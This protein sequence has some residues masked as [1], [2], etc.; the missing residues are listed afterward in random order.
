[1]IELDNFFQ[2]TIPVTKSFIEYIKHHPMVFEVFGHYQVQALHKVSMPEAA[3]GAQVG[4]G[5][6][7]SISCPKG[8]EM[9]G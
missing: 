4:S 2:I 8:G 1:M 6:N 9:L 3:A 7:P 5:S